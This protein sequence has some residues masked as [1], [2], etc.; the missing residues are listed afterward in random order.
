MISEW[1]NL[2]NPSGQQPEPEVLKD[3]IYIASQLASQL[4]EHK[5]NT[6]RSSRLATWLT[7]SDF[8]DRPA[9]ASPKR[10]LIGSRTTHKKKKKP[11]LVSTVMD[12]DLG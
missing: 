6:Y 7:S 3:N 9:M 12:Y 1:D 8:P 4:S 5:E 11:T 10:F 2:T